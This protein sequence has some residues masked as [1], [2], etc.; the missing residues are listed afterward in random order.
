MSVKL[1][2]NVGSSDLARS[3]SGS[4]YVEVDVN[5]DRIIFTNGSSLVIDGAPTP[6]EAALNQAAPLIDGSIKTVSKA[7]LLDNS[8]GKIEEIYGYALNAQY[9]FCAAF[10]AA[11]NSE[12]TLEL[13]DDSSLVSSDLEALGEGTPS[14]SWYKAIATTSSLPGVSWVGTALAGTSDLDL[15]EGSGAL[16]VATDLYF[17]LKVTIPATAATAFAILP[18]FAIKFS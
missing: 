5:N 17:N 3:D 18:V 1:Y 13:W 14:N 10:D 16:A 12:P 15:N 7:F 9:V 6:T 8:T 2:V 4:S 11:T